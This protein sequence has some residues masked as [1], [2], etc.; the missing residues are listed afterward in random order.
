MRIP[1]PA[2]RKDETMTTTDTDTVAALGRIE[3]QAL[4][5][6][7]TG[8]GQFVV[9]LTSSVTGEIGRRPVRGRTAAFQ[10]AQRMLGDRADDELRN[11]PAPLHGEVITV[12]IELEIGGLF[13]FRG[14]ARPLVASASQREFAVPVGAV[15]VDE[16][17]CLQSLWAAIA[18]AT[19]GAGSAPY[20]PIAAVPG[21]QL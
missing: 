6:P 13:E 14:L 12:A 16:P 2:P 11:D 3:H 10:V 21:G 17:F 20:P 15:A 9:I 8:H 4:L 7:A 18:S 1:I 5:T 19:L